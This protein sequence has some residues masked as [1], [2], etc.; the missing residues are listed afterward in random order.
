MVFSVAKCHPHR[1]AHRPRPLQDGDLW[2]HLAAVLPFVLLFHLSTHHL[3][4]FPQQR[5][6]SWRSW[7]PTLNKAADDLLYIHCS[8]YTHT[9]THI[10]SYP[11]QELQREANGAVAPADWGLEES[12]THTQRGGCCRRSGWS[13]PRPVTPDTVETQ[14]AF[15]I[16]ALRRTW[17]LW[18]GCDLHLIPAILLS[19][20]M[21]LRSTG[22]LV[23]EFL[24]LLWLWCCYRVV[25][26]TLFIQRTPSFKRRWFSALERL[27]HP[28]S[29]EYCLT[30]LLFDRFNVSITSVS[31][32][33]AKKIQTGPRL[34][35]SSIYTNIEFMLY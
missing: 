3:F 2:R 18:R 10:Y 28:D 29:L 20:F 6:R 9:H 25:Q 31:V 27:L 30:P 16:T 14:L 8:L 1:K 35:L 32:S 13:A 23:Y 7:I 5:R 15:S 21:S 22:V 12:P 26:V 24:A 17:T 33:V 34:R 4:F 11:T 19:N